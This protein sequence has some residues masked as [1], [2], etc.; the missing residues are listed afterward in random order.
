M[1]YENFT[2]I[3]YYLEIDLNWGQIIDG[4]KYSHLNR[5]VDLQDQICKDTRITVQKVESCP[6]NDTHFHERS[7]MKNCD[8]YPQ[9]EGE[10]LA[11]HC[12]RYKEYLVEVCTPLK[13]IRGV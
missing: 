7:K 5:Y 12:A 10:P 3:L 11:Y 6:E 1:I 8:S 13:F 4:S 2:C 9:C